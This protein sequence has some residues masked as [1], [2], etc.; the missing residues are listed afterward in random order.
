MASSS[1]E[2]DF[3]VVC[4]DTETTG[5]PPFRRVCILS[6]AASLDDQHTFSTFM[7]PDLGDLCEEETVQA[8]K[9]HG[10]E[11]ASLRDE[12]TAKEAITRFFAWL[13]EQRSGRRVLLVAHN[14]F[15]F[16]QPLLVTVCARVGVSVP[17]WIRFADSMV[18][19]RRLDA[20]NKKLKSFKLADLVESLGR[21][22]EG[23]HSAVVDQA[24]VRLIMEHG[25]FPRADVMAELKAHAR[26]P[27]H[28][29]PGSVS[30][31]GGSTV[32]DHAVDG[33]RCG[34]LGGVDG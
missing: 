22:T 10:I 9:I 6:L 16:D 25:P 14:G 8:S 34:A 18:A 28:F 27:T 2:S 21:S 7:K 19:L 30:S 5:L 13:D 23:A 32:P 17:D 12:P 29:H 11:L 4:W 26:P 20:E 31:H 33:G 24:W 15:R 3:A 1:A